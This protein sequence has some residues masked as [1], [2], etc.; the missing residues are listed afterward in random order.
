MN[1]LTF[2]TLFRGLLRRRFLT[3]IQI[4]GLT[5][6]FTIVLFLLAKID[7]ER[8]YDTFWKD[9]QSVYRLGLDLAYSDGR[10][11]HSAKNFH[12]SSELLH[13]EVPG[14]KAHC[15]LAPDVITVYFQEKKIQDVDWFWSDSTFFNVF[16]RKL[17][18]KEAGPVLGD[19]HGIAIS[20]S[21]AHKLFG[22]ENPLNKE[23]SLNEGWKFLIKGVF[24][25]IPDNSHLKIDVLGSYQSLSYYMK[26][27]DV[28]NQVL[29]E[30]PN[31]DFQ[32]P[33]PYTRNRWTSSI[34]YRPYCY[35]RLDD[36]TRISE[37][38]SAVQPAIQKV[39]LPPAL[40]KSKIN[41]VFQPVS[42]IHLHSTLDNELRMKGSAMQVNF[43]IIIGLV[44]LIVCVVNF[45]NLSTIATF[46]DRKSNAIKL[47]NGSRKLNILG[48]LTMQNL[49]ICFLSLLLALPLSLVVIRSQI[50]AGIISV[51]VIL[52]ILLIAGVSA[53]LASFVPYISVFRTPIFQTLKGQSNS[54]GDQKWSSRKALIVMQ[55]AI[56]IILI[57]STIGIYK[58]MNF[59]MRENLG[60]KGS[61]SVFCF[62]PMS[63]TNHPD[64]PV[65]LRT[66][67]DE[68]LAL[69]G[70]NSFSVS[71]S[72]P[73]REIFR[74]QENIMPSGSS[75]PFA[76][77]FSQVS[78]D[79][80]FLET[81]DIQLIAGANFEE[82]SNW[83]SDEVL[84]NRSAA[85]AMGFHDPS[86]AIGSS[87]QIGTKAYKVKGVIENY[88]HVSLHYQIK[89]AIYFQ[90]LVWDKSVGFYSFNL[91]SAKI[92]EVMTD[93]GKIW[94][95]LYPKDDFIYFFSDKEFET[96]YIDDLKFNHILT[97][98]AILALIIS[99][100]GLL[101]LAIFNTKQ[102]I[103]EIGIRKVNGATI[104]EI[105]VMLNSDFVKWVAIA[106]VIALP[107]AYYAMNKWIENF[108]Y[109]TSLSWW[110]FALAGLLALGI[111]L[112]TVS[113]QSWKAA[114][115]NPVEALRYE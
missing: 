6:G 74:S 81:Y 43:L 72:V 109:K 22:N 40:E 68:V 89:P 27:Y 103:K 65:K 94:K 87:F 12:G 105:L 14:I 44:V 39:G 64:I 66:F 91:K 112:L 46:D 1:N 102:R 49:L 45:L 36:K 24:E 31:F 50:P 85:D 32:K 95:R 108:A 75:E 42:S 83:A 18:Y 35:I 70:V 111:A 96:Q 104:S 61:Q 20:Q 97:Y 93:V 15:N 7:Y 63:M 11:I 3:L 16:E 28:K 77:P 48:A 67:R 56:T 9:N 5:I 58:Q 26:N 8:S 86:A 110:I 107:V 33:S 4:G 71:S 59:V 114:T 88:H 21:F 51:P 57:I 98:S 62:T 19:L 10:A 60:F 17:I 99:S 54:L 37:V 38:A 52:I 84:V 80:K 47:L 30:N 90:D 113:W 76:S 106:F 2:K 41:F 79:E 25:D 34:Q 53:F 73:G 101:S 55:F 92:S 13:A 29:V 69:P 23:I 82:R 100:L 78:I 115:R